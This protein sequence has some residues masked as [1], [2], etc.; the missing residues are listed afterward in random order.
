MSRRTS[1]SRFLVLDGRTSMAVSRVRGG[2]GT[3]RR[4]VAGAAGSCSW[5]A[6]GL[7]VPAC[8]A[9]PAA[10]Q[11]VPEDSSMN[12][13]RDPLGRACLNTIGTRHFIVKSVYPEMGEIARILRVTLYPLG[14]PYVA[15][16]SGSVRSPPAVGAVPFSAGLLAVMRTF[17]DSIC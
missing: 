12:F 2:A 17:T 16:A 8:S 5:D 7:P 1:C 11:L 15:R 9:A 3:G 10:L 14:R 6:G 13:K 4:C